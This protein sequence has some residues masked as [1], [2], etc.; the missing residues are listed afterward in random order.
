M[1]IPIIDKRIYN[2]VTILSIL[3]NK[4]GYNS[5]ENICDSLKLTK[6]MYYEFMQKLNGLVVA[7]SRG[8]NGGYSYIGADVTIEEI[9]KH[10]SLFEEVSE[11]IYSQRLATQMKRLTRLTIEEFAEVDE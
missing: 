10:L 3:K 6:Y 9:L 5:L 11:T 1:L 8:T 4:G 2:V 7:S